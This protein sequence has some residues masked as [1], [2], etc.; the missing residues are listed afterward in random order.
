M[1]QTTEQTKQTS[2]TSAEFIN[3]IP[4]EGGSLVPAD[5]KGDKKVTKIVDK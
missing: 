3:S 1:I 4:L 5:V 2:E